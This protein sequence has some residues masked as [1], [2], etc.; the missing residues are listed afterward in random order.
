MHIRPLMLC[1]VMIVV[2]MGLATACA[3]Q[4]VSSQKPSPEAVQRSKPSEK[5]GPEFYGPALA[6]SGDREVYLVWGS[7]DFSK[8]FDTLFSRSRT[9]GRTWLQAA[10]LKPDTSR[11]N[12]ARY[13]RADEK[14]N[15]SVLWASGLRTSK[16]EVIFT[17]SD[18]QGSSWAAPITLSASNDLHAPYLIQSPNGVLYAIIPDGPEQNWNLTIARSS[19]GGKSWEDLPRLINAAGPRTMFGIRE[20]KAAADDQGRLHVV[21][22]EKD[23]PAKEVIYYN[24]FTPAAAGGG[25]T[26]LSEAIPLSARAPDSSGAYRPNIAIDRD[27]HILVVWVE[28]WN[29]Q[30]VDYREGRLPQ[31]VYFNR[32]LDSGTSWLPEPIRLSRSGLA[33]IKTVATWADVVSNGKGQVYVAWKQED[34]YPPIPR[35]LFAGSPDFGSTWTSEPLV[36]SEGSRG[37]MVAEP[38]LLRSGG[39]D[40]VYLLWQEVGG[41]TWKLLFTRSSD[42]G[43]SWPATPFRLAALPQA[44]R[45]AHGLSFETRGPHL[46]V[47]WEGGPVVPGE[48]YMNRSVD[49]GERWFPEE[50]QVSQR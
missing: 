4:E 31:A 29:P 49:F 45:G 17:R 36:L 40:H 11:H 34:A 43:K 26:W 13:I 1:Q 22:E 42:Q 6:L 38:L 44:N 50:V 46:Y 18:D 10:S 37:T 15:V 41:P 32:S 19:D 39:D 27:G 16:R 12:A 24:R 23:R 33:A 5:K 7:T 25:G 47:A 20:S 35:I 8:N 3:L 9:D 48:I 2:M 14:G 30:Q 28:G 21:W